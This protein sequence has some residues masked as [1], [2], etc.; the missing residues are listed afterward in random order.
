MHDLICC[1][2]YTVFNLIVFILRDESFNTK[3]LVGANNEPLQQSML[4]QRKTR[5]DQVSHNNNISIPL[6][7]IFW[8]VIGW[9][10]LVTEKR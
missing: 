3:P 9:F 8:V 1:K 2:L 7:N 6:Q 4:R 5:T 10:C